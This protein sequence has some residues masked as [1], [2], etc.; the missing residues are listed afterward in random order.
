[1]AESP[2]KSTNFQY[3]VL[4]IVIFTLLGI[5]IWQIVSTRIYT[6]RLTLLAGNTKINTVYRLIEN[7][8]VDTL[9][10]NQLEESAINAM[11]KELDPHS[12]YLPAKKVT[13]ANEMLEGN[14]YGIGV[15]YQIFRDTVVITGLI[16]NGPSEAAGILPGDRIVSVE[17]SIVAGNATANEGISTLLKGPDQ[18]VVHVQIKRRGFAELI[19][20]E[21]TRG[22]IPINSIDVAY[23]HTPETGYIK[24]NKFSR[25]THTE[26]LTAVQNLKAAGMRKLILDLRG[27][28][29][30]YMDPAIGILGEFFPKDSLLVYTQGR[31]RSRNDYY[32][33]GNLACDSIA[34]TILID[35]NSASSTEIVAGAIQDYERGIIIGRRSF[36]K[37]LVQEQI[38]LRDGS[39][40]RITV[41]RYYT[42]SGRSI[43]K[44][45]TMG[46]DT[47]YGQELYTRYMH[48]EMMQSDS[49]KVDLSNS[50][51]TLKSHK[52]VYGG[53][54]IVPDIFVPLDTSYLSPYFSR[55]NRLTLP[56]LFAFEYADS[57]RAELST[58]SDYKALQNALD[59][60]GIMDQFVAYTSEQ[61]IVPSA[62]DL[63]SSGSFIQNLISAYISRHIFNDEGFYPILNADDVVFQCA[64][65]ALDETSSYS[66]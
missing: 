57:H 34:L 65:K 14:F 26:F 6:Q 64:L 27:N 56:L 46:E 40:L 51:Q 38:E 35:E 66:Y 9:N 30:G 19:E 42:P 37:G 41:A 7:L 60:K 39:A 15:Q 18:S 13:S 54:G 62:K 43:Q 31:S 22:S 32:G 47:D 33:S 48:G 17:D 55:I 8:Y 29:G 44:P 10:N 36:G 5:L 3:L 20:K 21:I 50:F 28:T 45:Y 16:A 59:E 2:K 4:G 12:L 63:Q 23:M 52:I 25:A 11:V 61:G 53:G 24:L 58:Y 49:I 1:M